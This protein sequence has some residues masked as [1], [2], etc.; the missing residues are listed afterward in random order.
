MWERNR[1]LQQEA[2]SYLNKKANT[3]PNDV[4][5]PLEVPEKPKD[6]KQESY[7]LTKEEVGLAKK[8]A[9]HRNFSRSFFGQEGQF[10]L[11]NIVLSSN[12]ESLMPS[13]QENYRK[14]FTLPNYVPKPLGEVYKDVIN[15][16]RF[17]AFLEQN[18]ELVMNELKLGTQQKIIF[19]HCFIERRPRVG[20]NEYDLFRNDS[21]NFLLDKH[22]RVRLLLEEYYKKFKS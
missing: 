20:L 8:L 4:E 7:E 1:G 6:E 3:I 15:R 22:E 16:I 2:E 11:E 10:V 13:V 21:Y 9:T 19:K 12:A 14:S 5:S 17:F 18:Q